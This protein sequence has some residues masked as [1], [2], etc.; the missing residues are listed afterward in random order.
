MPTMPMRPTGAASRP[1]SRIVTFGVRARCGLHRE[2]HRAVDRA[3]TNSPRAS[4]SSAR[5]ARAPIVLQGRRRAQ[6]LE[7]ARRR[8]RGRRRGRV[9]RGHRGRARGFSRGGRP[10]AAQGGSARQLDHRRFLQRQSELGAR[11]PRC[12]A[13]AARADLA[14][15]RRHGRTRRAHASDSHAELGRYARECGVKRLFALGPESSRAV[16]TFGS[17]GEWFADA[18]SLIRRLQ[19]EIAPGVTVLVKGSRVNRLERVVQALGGGA[20]SSG[21][22]MRAS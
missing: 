10:A 21:P 1:R 6:H 15:A 3:R 11:R 5:W 19:A 8:R 17:G 12:A 20:A 14:G 13:Y 16:E 4:R 9:A 7:R 18:E 22:M 2:G